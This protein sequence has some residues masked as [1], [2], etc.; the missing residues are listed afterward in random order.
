MKGIEVKRL[1]DKE[2]IFKLLME[3]EPLLSDSFRDDNRDLLQYAEKLSQNAHIYMAERNGTWLA[4]IGGY[5]NNKELGSFVSFWVTNPNE[6]GIVAAIAGGEVIISFVEEAKARGLGKTTIE[7]NVNNIHARQI[8]EKIGFTIVEK[9]EK[10]YIM[11]INDSY[12]EY[13]RLTN[14]DK[15]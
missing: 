6:N 15:R 11:Q 12:E 13:L 3:I 10:S 7:V 8:Y 5:I 9:R 14:F 1:T 2:D 4:V